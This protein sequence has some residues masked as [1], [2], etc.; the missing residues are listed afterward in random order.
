MIKPRTNWVEIAAEAGVDQHVAQN[1]DRRKPHQ[2]GNDRSASRHESAEADDQRGQREE[3]H[4]DAGVRADAVLS[5]REEKRRQADDHAGDDV[6]EEH[7]QLDADPSVSRSLSIAADCKNV[8]TEPRLPEHEKDQ[9]RNDGEDPKADG[10]SQRLLGADP[11]P[12][13]VAARADGNLDQLSLRREGEQAAHRDH[14]ADRRQQRPAAEQSRKRPV[15]GADQ[16]SAPEAGAKKDQN[17]QAQNMKTIERDERRHREVGADRQI[18]AADSHNDQQR[19]GHQR[20]VSGE[21]GQVAR[22]GGADVSLRENE[23]ADRQGDECDERNR[24][25]DPA[26]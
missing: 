20:A 22:V 26:L 6:S 14:H 25:L 18:D 24:A 3:F 10:Y 1:V 16:R 8:P 2:N 17:R 12:Q 5:R 15:D 4:A 23:D 11:I 19:K 21:L 13:I 7:R 9:R